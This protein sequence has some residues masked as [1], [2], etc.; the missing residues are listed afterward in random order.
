MRCCPELRRLARLPLAVFAAVLA[1]AAGAWA[2]EPACESGKYQQ[3]LLLRYEDACRAK[4]EALLRRLEAV[5]KG[6]YGAD[7]AKKG[8]N[9]ILRE[10]LQG[11]ATQLPQPA[12]PGAAPFVDT[13]RAR[14]ARAIAAAEAA[15]F[16]D[17]ALQIDFWGPF[18]ADETPGPD[19]LDARGCSDKTEDGAGCEAAYAQA[20]QIADSMFT[21]KNVVA[22]YHGPERDKLR[23]QL[24]LRGDRW[25]AYLYGT[26]F[27]YWWELGAN[28]YLAEECPRY[29]AMVAAAV[30]KKC[31][32]TVRDDRGNVI[33]WRNPPEYKAILLHPDVG[34]QYGRA[35]PKG[36]RLKPTLVFQ[37]LGYQWWD[38]DGGKATALRG[39]ALVS[40]VSDNKSGH[41]LGHG[42][43][44]QVNGYAVAL[45][46][47]GGRA[48]IT[49]SLNLA[50]KLSKVNEDAA[51]KLKLQ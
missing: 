1:F 20:A 10:Q 30:G 9:D 51:N 26:Q 22:A 16:D 25:E 21:V 14:L 46:A 40:T 35:Q 27:Q 19:Y 41:T 42:V 37:W 13:L 44:V 12:A 15:Q 24:A 48:A 34:V 11:Q 17:D 3:R 47:H 36:D 6:F 18:D 28:R 45:T 50:E 23:S 39:V 32:K 8:W 2:Q 31:E 33:A 5:A 29:H 38:W 7:A 49:I 4:N 43:Q